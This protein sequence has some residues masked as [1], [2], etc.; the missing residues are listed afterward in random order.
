[1]N[2]NMEIVTLMEI[3]IIIQEITIEINININITKQDIRTIIGRI[4]NIT[5]K[6]STRDKNIET[7]ISHIDNYIK[8]TINSMEII[9]I[10]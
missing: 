2:T 7:K 8:Q 10:K 4:I 6:F 5:T 3:K 9:Q 1:M